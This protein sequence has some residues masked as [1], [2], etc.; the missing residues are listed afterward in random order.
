MQGK[1]SCAAPEQ[2]HCFPV[3]SHGRPVRQRRIRAFADGACAELWARVL[4][5]AV[6]ANGHDARERRLRPRARI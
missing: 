1:A 6:E 3:R 5:G 4:R 2:R